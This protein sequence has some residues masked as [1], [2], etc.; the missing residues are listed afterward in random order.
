MPRKGLDTDDGPSEEDLERF[1][2]VTQVCPACRTELYDDVD[3]C[4]KCGRPLAG[5]RDGVKWWV[6]ALA[7]LA[8]LIVVVGLIRGF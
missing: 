5:E 1:A 7:G 2:G 4:W 3:L 8:G 6:W